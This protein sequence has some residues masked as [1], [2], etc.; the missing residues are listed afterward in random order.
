MLEIRPNCEC[1]GRDVAPDSRDVFICTFECTWCRSCNDE[2]LHGTYPN[3]GG[4]L[5]RRPIRPAAALVRHPASTVRVVS[6][7]CLGPTAH[8]A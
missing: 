2:K 4:E 6:D 5:V 8:L 3:C 7:S 1:C